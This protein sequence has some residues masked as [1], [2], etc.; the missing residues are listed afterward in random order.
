MF[1]L[2][3]TKQ[4]ER[5]FRL[6]KKRGYRMQLLQKVLADL[7]LSGTVSSNHRPHKL[8]GNYNNFWECH[9]QPDWLLI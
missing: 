2:S 4:F 9:I 1:T 6:C 3:T 5:D 7:E 8:I